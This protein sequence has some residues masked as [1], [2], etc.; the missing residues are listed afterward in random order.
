MRTMRGRPST[1]GTW[2]G[3]L[4][5]CCWLPFVVSLFLSVA[6][7]RGALAHREAVEAASTELAGVMLRDFFDLA[8]SRASRDAVG[9]VNRALGALRDQGTP[10]VEPAT[11]LDAFTAG[12]RDPGME[13]LPVQGIGVMNP[14][15]GEVANSQGRYAD[16]LR[17]F[18]GVGDWRDL[19]VGRLLTQSGSDGDGP[20]FG[21]VMMIP[22]DDVSV[23]AVAMDIPLDSMAARLI[24][25]ALDS[26]QVHHL[27]QRDGSLGTRARPPGRVRR[28]HGWGAGQ[29]GYVCAALIRARPP[30]RADQGL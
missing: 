24:G 17:R 18:E 28:L 8:L 11:V 14:R 3:L 6:Y 10:V 2:L 30:I 21:Y 12:Q 15:T 20:W 1:S 23:F 5:A 22:I 26:V 25:P 27:G 19:P 9:L 13:W 7:V 29:R 16:W 4:I